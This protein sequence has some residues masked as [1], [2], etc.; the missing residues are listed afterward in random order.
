[1]KKLIMALVVVC[2]VGCE[3]STKEISGAFNMPEELKDCKMYGL[4]NGV[5]N[6]IIVRCPQSLTSTTYNCGKTTCSSMTVEV[7]TVGFGEYERLKKKFNK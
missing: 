7:D 5:K 6:V 3:K 2:L 4:S 1:M